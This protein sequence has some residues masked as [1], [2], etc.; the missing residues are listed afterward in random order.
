MKAETKR[1]PLEARVAAWEEQHSMQKVEVKLKTK[2]EMAKLK[3]DIVDSHK[4][5]PIRTEWC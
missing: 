3:T 5:H 2:K 1:S 4:V